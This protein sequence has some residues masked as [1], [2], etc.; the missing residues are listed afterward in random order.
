M[1]AAVALWVIVVALVVVTMDKFIGDLC[2]DGRVVAVLREYR[3]VLPTV[4]LRH[5]SVVLF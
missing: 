2:E 4:V 5:R 3:K 1:V